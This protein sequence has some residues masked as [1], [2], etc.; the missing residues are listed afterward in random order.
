MDRNT[1]TAIFH[2]VY[3][4]SCKSS[5]IYVIT[6][7]F[8]DM[9]ISRFWCAHISRHFNFAILRNLIFWITLITRFE[10]HNLNFMGNNV[11]IAKHN[12]GTKCQLYNKAVFTTSTS[13]SSYLYVNF[14]SI[15]HNIHLRW[16]FLPEEQWKKKKNL[17]VV[18]TS[19]FLD[20]WLEV[21]HLIHLIFRVTLI[22][23]FFS[24]REIREINVSR[25]FHVIR[26]IRKKGLKLKVQCYFYIW[27]FF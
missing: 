10:H 23:R 25:K 24:C 19:F 7:N 13:S 11:K 4:R 1:L 2:W 17:S 22:S 20:Y 27:S 14:E 21:S 18:I 5:H 15:D 16:K 3:S 6:W 8:C 12:S 26:N 9:S